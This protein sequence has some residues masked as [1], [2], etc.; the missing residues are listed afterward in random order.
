MIEGRDCTVRT[1]NPQQIG[2]V[3]ENP[4]IP[5]MLSAHVSYQ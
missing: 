1:T 2:P 5:Q 3:E 4:T